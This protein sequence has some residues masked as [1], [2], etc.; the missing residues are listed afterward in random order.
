ME[1]RVLGPF[2]VWRAGDLL[3]IGGPKP[4]AVL[5]VLVVNANRVVSV[6]RL[7]DELWG[8]HPPPT[9]AKALQT[10]VSALR[11]TLEPGRTAG[12]PPR[13]LVTRGAGYVLEVDRNHIDAH[14]FEH[15]AAEGRDALRTGRPEVAATALEEALALWRGP[16]FAEF[17]DHD[18]L[19]AE[20][21]RLQELRLAAA[22]D[23][24]ATYLALGREA[25]VVAEAKSLLREHPLRERLWAHLMLAH[26]R[27]GRQAEALRA[28]R[29]AR[30]IVGDELGI[31]PS[32]H[33]QQLERAILLQDPDLARPRR[34]SPARLPSQPTTLIGREEAVRRACSLLAEVRLLTITGAPGVGKTRLAVEVAS[35]LADLFGH[36]T[37]FVDL[38]EVG[39]APMVLPTVARTI[40]LVERAD[41]PLLAQLEH[42]LHDRYLLLVMDNFE[43]VTAAASHVAHL[44]AA[45]PDLKV[46]TTSREPLRVTW[47]HE[48]PLAPLELPDARWPGDSESAL[49]APAVELFADRAR[50]VIPDFRLD[51]DQAR[52]AVEICR[53]LD[54][55]PLAIELAAARVR[56]LSPEAILSRLERGLRLLRSDTRNAAERHRTLHHA[57]AWSY[58]LLASEEQV[59]FRRLG[60]FVGGSTLDAVAAVA[61]D[62]GADVLDVVTSMVAKNLLVRDVEADGEPRFRMLETIRE[63]AIEEL[64]PRNQV[65][66]R[67]RHATFYLELAERAAPELT[68]ADQAAWLIRLEQDVA[69]FAGAQDW[70]I[71]HDPLV[72]LR[73]AVALGSFWYRRGHFAEGRRRLRKALA[74]AD[75][76]APPRLRAD[77]LLA[78]GWLARVQGDYAE[79]TGRLEECLS[80][81]RL[82]GDARGTASTLAT[83]SLV[84][85]NQGDLRR[86]RRLAEEALGLARGAG[87]LPAEASALN[88]LGNVLQREGDFDGA[89]ELFQRAQEIWEQLGDKLSMANALTNLGNVANDQCDN[90]QAVQYHEE[91][92]AIRR[93]IDDRLTMS[94]ALNNLGNVLS[95]LGRESEAQSVYEESL[96]VARKRGERRSMGFALNGLGGVA[97]AR[98]HT[99]AARRLLSE[100]LHI[101]HRLG[102]TLEVFKTL[103]SL[104]RLAVAVGEPDRAVTL[105]A[106]AT[107]IRE[108]I[109]ATLRPA[110][111]PLFA[112]D[113]PL[114][115]LRLGNATYD[116]AWRAGSEMNLD[117]AVDY[118][119]HAE[120]SLVPEDHGLGV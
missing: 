77:A 34:G 57:I 62:S 4:C 98:G 22:E 12:D 9:A 84:A 26:Y 47:E 104:A 118:A 41:E 108:S 52:A 79:A 49:R 15:R 103:E 32:P 83:L 95:A 75:A 76:A 88:N 117:R 36:D 71:D 115:Q 31:E 45:C 113:L 97:L 24:L 107:A 111:Q 20:A 55:L 35:R 68:R 110:D 11:K 58:D 54:G 85:Y 60:V 82:L 6:D 89:R 48:F 30:R 87:F 81:R 29:K 59:V 39:E 3:R 8:D 69:N 67:R 72:A 66:A 21:E 63:F 38:S 46:V 64:S 105:G 18:A 13:V 14:R 42:Y 16:P 92:L 33:L 86:G 10:Y 27:L 65:D 51:D 78:A 109:G 43:Q 90:A 61:D 119:L 94:L 23:A 19:R 101:R 53:R 40:G 44:V 102:E 80:L 70:A 100:A 28:Y 74:T 96:A 91:S 93:D 5:A 112:T 99:E 1:F 114:I 56:V 116:A 7:I 17:G 73:I 37:V 106:A 2:E 50:A 25:E 120:A